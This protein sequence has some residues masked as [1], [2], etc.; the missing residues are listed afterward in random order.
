[1]CASEGEEQLRPA[2]QAQIVH[3]ANHAE[4]KRHSPR[5][6]RPRVQHAHREEQRQRD[7]AVLEASLPLV[8]PPAALLRT[9]QA[10]RAGVAVQPA[11]HPVHHPAVVQ[12][13]LHPSTE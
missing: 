3:E 11:E 10:G 2:T 9:R 1:M 7:R 13:A 4:V 5:A 8:L 6:A 12:A